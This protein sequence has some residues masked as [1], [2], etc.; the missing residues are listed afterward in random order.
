LERGQHDAASGSFDA[1]SEEEAARVEES[2]SNGSVESEADDD[3]V[4]KN[5]VDGFS[6]DSDSK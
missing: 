4:F 1:I 5:D 3:N 2:M 6:S